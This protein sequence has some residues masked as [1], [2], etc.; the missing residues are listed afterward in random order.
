MIPLNRTLIA[1][2]L[3]SASLL[4]CAPSLAG[5]SSANELSDAQVAQRV[6]S[7]L[8]QMTLPEKIGQITQ[9]GPWPICVLLIVW[10]WMN[11]PTFAA[12]AFTLCM[13]TVGLIENIAKPFALSHGLK[14]PMPVTFLGVIGGVMTHGIGGLFMGPVVLAVAWE[15]A[16]TWIEGEEAP[17]A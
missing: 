17:E 3:P 11:L 7:L 10:G 5:Q 12:L 16:K 8:A 4:I 13:L 14:T 6:E 9:I 15:L 2:I 1:F